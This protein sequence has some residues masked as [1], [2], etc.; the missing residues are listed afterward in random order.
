M[1]V[2]VSGAT[3]LIGRALSA[4]LE[5]RGDVVVTL[6]RRP[7]KIEGPAVG[8][9]LDENH[10]DEGALEDVDAVIHLAGEGIARQRWTPG[11]KNRVLQSRTRSTILLAEAIAAASA[12]PKVFVSASAIGF[13]GSRGD[14]RLDEAATAGEGFLA[15]VCVAWEAAA[16][17]ARR[18]GVRVVHP[19]IGVVL[20]SEGGALEK[21]LTPFKLGMGGR[22]GSG[23]QYMPWISLRDVVGI[24]L[25]GLDDASISGPLNATAPEPATNTD[26]TRALGHA[27]ARPTLVPL[28]AFAAK[29]ALGAEMAE[30]LLLSSTRAVPTKALEHGY[31][32]EDENLGRCLEEMLKRP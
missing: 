26:F 1:R 16:E 25:L 13:Y 7:E 30:E 5:A 8:W 3:G 6:T 22:I 11:H 4:H 14:T 17:P 18:A 28:P 10:L 27:L 15:D 23:R 2:L 19:R 24:L 29:L 12:P 20:S 9:N 32:F 31:T 21:M